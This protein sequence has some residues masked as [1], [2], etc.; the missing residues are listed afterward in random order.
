M[1]RIFFLPHTLPSMFNVLVMTPP[2][3]ERGSGDA[4]IVSGAGSSAGPC[5][6]IS[7]QLSRLFH[8]S[9]CTQGCHIFSYWEHRWGGSRLWPCREAVEDG[10]TS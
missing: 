3:G 4:V 5:F 9:F 10:L 8:P 6:P 1:Q 7:V 2:V